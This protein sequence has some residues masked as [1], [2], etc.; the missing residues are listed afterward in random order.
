MV[1]NMTKNWQ[2]PPEMGFEGHNN[3]ECVRKAKILG[4]TIS[5]DLRW[6]YNSKYIVDKAMGR[7][8]ILR[9]M[10]NLGLTNDVIYDVYIKEIR[11][12]LEFGVPVWNGGLSEENSNDIEKVQKI[13]F[14]IL[15]M[16]KYSRYEDA[17]KN[18]TLNH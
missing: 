9:R 7:V 16:N 10:K 2:F 14:K 15:L 8:W 4:I 17:C 6:N 13:V 3:L 11:S 1:F 12:I 5:D 18:S